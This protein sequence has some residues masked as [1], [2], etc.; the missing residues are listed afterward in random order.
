MACC[1]SS[2]VLVPLLLRNGAKD[3]VHVLQ[4]PSPGLGQEKAADGAESANCGKEEELMVNSGLVAR[5]D[6]KN[7]R[8]LLCR[9][10]QS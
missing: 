9:E 6:I 5:G 1:S 7:S 10:L 2:N 8:Y 3:Y 4:R